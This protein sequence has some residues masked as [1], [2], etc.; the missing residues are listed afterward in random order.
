MR[1]Y[2]RLTT[3]YQN[4]PNTERAE[5]EEILP[6]IPSELGKAKIERCFEIGFVYSTSGS[7]FLTVVPRLWALRISLGTR[8]HEQ[9]LSGIN[10]LMLSRVEVLS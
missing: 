1:F 2:L 3:P 5:S 7:R 4:K 6:E 9:Y 10:D 8:T